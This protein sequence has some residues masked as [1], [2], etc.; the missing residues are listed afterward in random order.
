MQPSSAPPN[1]SE[2]LR[3]QL[4]EEL[5]AQEECLIMNHFE[6]FEKAV[7][8]RDKAQESAAAPVCGRSKDSH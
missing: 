1:A 6:E 7:D 4:A 2:E 3:K 5:R 8:Q